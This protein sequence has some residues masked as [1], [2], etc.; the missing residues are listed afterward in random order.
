MVGVFASRVLWNPVFRT[1]MFWAVT[2]SIA[3]FVYLAWAPFPLSSVFEILSEATHGDITR[4]STQPFAFSLAVAIGAVAAGLLA[5][6]LLMHALLAP[7]AIWAAKRIIERTSSKT[8]F[9]QAIDRI[10]AHLIGHPLLGH[11][12]AKFDEAVVRHDERLQNTVRPQAFFNY[13][14]LREKLVGLKIMSGVPSYF[15][16]VGLL[17]T[18]VGLVIALSKAAEGT[19]AAQMAAGGAGAAAMQSALREL[20]HAA[21]F[22]FATSI[23]GL[24]ASIVLSLAFRLFAVRVEASLNAFCEA[25][26]RKLDYIA[27]QSVSLQIRDSLKEQVDELKAINS[28][29]FFARLGQEVGPSINSAFNSAISPLLQQIGDAVSQLSANSQSGVQE[30]VQRFSDSVQFGAGAEMRELTA[31][32]H[33]MLG[34]ME[35]A[36]SDVG[37]SGEDF[38][39]RMAE[40]AENLSRLVAEAGQNLGQQSNRSRETVEQM[41]ASL[42]EIFDQATKQIDANLAASAE[43]A[44]SKLSEA[45]DRVL[46]QLQG[47]V[48]ALNGS[49]EGFQASSTALADETRRHVAEAQEKSVDTIAAISARV[50]ATLE[51]GLAGAMAAIRKQVEEFSS[52]LQASSASLGQQA[53]AI[54]Q[55]TLRSRETAEVFGQSAQAIRGAVEPVTRSNEKIAAVTQGVGESLR[56][57]ASAVVESQKAF[58]SLS[59]AI[60]AQTTRLTEIW[61]DYEKRF[62]KVDEDLGRAFEKL[63][64]ET[65]KQSMILADQTTKI[66]AGLARAIDKLAPF[67]KDIGE[68]AGELAESV[69]DLKN[70]FMVRVGAR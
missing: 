14:A 65:T 41:L 46:G 37:Q 48:Q 1:L 27:P 17:L 21:T 26:E 15:V 63:A 3:R 36:R 56:Q 23:S 30:L 29:Q 54:D 45:M 44:S 2:I 51:E 39:K 40:A 61:G 12:W 49:L 50:A 43:G 28:E 10:N 62:G 55:A 18:F 34:A 19:E 20:L 6:F 7:L 67:V 64:A 69:E 31:G 22:K 68:G 70:V 24:A 58:T 8:E 16:G 52:A 59:Q 60:V 42:R 38:A 11:A 33:A 66:D 32:L 25:V 35:K 53:R 13:A 9:A 5:A 4:V 47:Q 57:A